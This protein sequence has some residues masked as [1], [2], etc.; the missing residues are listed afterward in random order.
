MAGNIGSALK[1][2]GLIALVAALFSA[3]PAAT[4]APP[5]A[6]G[7]LAAITAMRAIYGSYGGWQAA[8]YFSEEMHA[9]ERNVARAIF[10]GIAL[11]TALYLLVNAAALHVLPVGALAASK[12]AAADA[13]S[14]AFGAGSGVIVTALAILCVATLANTQILEL[15]RTNFAL[16]R[17]GRLPPALASVSAKGTPRRALMLGCVATALV[18]AIADHAREQLY[19]VLLDL[20]APFIMLIFLAMS[21]GAIVLR[22]AEPDLARPWKMPLYPLPAILSLVLNAGLLALFLIG[23]WKTGLWSALLL[24]CAVPLYWL[25][26][27]YWQKETAVG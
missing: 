3:R 6:F 25:G 23:D 24:A 15:T 17:A 8:I 2:L 19:E 12:L 21:Y 20:Y 14:A 11:V 16:A 22:R 13:A 26:R 7:W 4:P 1:A 10:A 5:P 18:I 27:R 9:P